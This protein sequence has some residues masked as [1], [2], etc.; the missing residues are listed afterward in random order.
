MVWLSETLWITAIF[1]LTYTWSFFSFPSSFFLYSFFPSFFLLWVAVWYR[2]KAI[3]ASNGKT[4]IHIWA[5]IHTS[6]LIIYVWFTSFLHSPTDAHLGCFHILTIVNNATVNMR[7]QIFLQYSDFTSF[8]CIP[9]S[10]TGES[11]GCS[12]FTFLRNLHTT[13]LS[14]NTNQL[15]SLPIMQKG[16]PSSTSSPTLISYLFD[17]RHRN[18]GEGEFHYSFGLHVHGD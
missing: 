10:G 12:I 16:S 6:C 1:N 9:K 17:D 5:L 11:H 3:G 18:R 15:K 4:R 7:G 8:G 2:G 14:D 13:F